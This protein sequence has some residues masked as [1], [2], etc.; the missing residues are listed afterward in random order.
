M[1]GVVNVPP[2]TVGL[3]VSGEP[4]V[5]AAYQFKLPVPVALNGTVPVPQRVPPVT[6]AIAGVITL[7]VTLEEVTLVHTIQRKSVSAVS[8]V[9]V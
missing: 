2:E 7:T 8:V 6:V 4:P 3:P 9:G 1:L 5:A